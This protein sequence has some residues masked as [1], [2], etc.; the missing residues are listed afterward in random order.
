[1]ID[2]AERRRSGDRERGRVLA[3]PLDQVLAPLRIGES[4]RTAITVYSL[5][6]FASGVTSV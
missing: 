6:R 1:M 3:Q 2:A 5:K 4:A